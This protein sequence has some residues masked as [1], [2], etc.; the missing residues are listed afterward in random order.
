MTGLNTEKVFRQGLTYDDVL[1]IPAHSQVL[2]QETDLRSRFSRNIFLNV[3]LVS[4]AMDTVTEAR[5]AIVMAREGGIGVI[6]KNMALESQ[7][8][9]VKAVKKSESGMITDPICVEPTQTVGDVLAL[10][11]QHNISGL[12]VLDH[13]RLV[14]IVTGRD[15]SFEV[16]LTKSV[17]DVM[18][19]EVV[20][21]VEGTSLEEAVEILHKH[22]IEKLPVLARG[23]QSLVGMFTIKDIEK[24]RRHPFASK[25][26]KG[27]LMVAAAVGARGDYLE[28]AEA[29][30]SEGVDAL[31]VDTAHG[32]S[33][34]VLDA[35]K[36][37]KQNFKSHSFDLLGGNIATADACKALVEA[38]ADGVKVGIGPGSI[39]T[40][41]IVAGIGVPQFTA[42]LDCA[43]Q[44]KQLGIPVIADGGIKYSGDVV[45]AL[46]AG[47]SAVMIGSLF[48]GT[49]ETPGEMVIYQGKSYKTYRGM[50]SIGA[51]VGGSKDRYFQSEVDEQGKLV[52]EGIE[53]RVP[54]KGPLSQSIFQMVGGIRAAMG[55]IGARHVESLQEKAE[56]MRI[57]PAGLRESHAHDVFITREAPNYKMD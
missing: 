49:D 5:A 43:R 26:S 23:S 38:G 9:E 25:D 33:Q 1:I 50:G 3:P 46:A 29:L 20:T 30:L 15:I 55:Y 34:L 7:A 12:P 6:H 54:Y 16:N 42:V 21:T 53:G 57:S 10:M 56:F 36:K 28:R 35:V 52:P 32:H 22:R 17:K 48:A 18:T 31:V 45:K 13:N 41:R 8:A 40:T 19:K 37:I 4:A 2:P 47:A 27:R 39:C 44:G 11:G 24:A 14:G 51:M